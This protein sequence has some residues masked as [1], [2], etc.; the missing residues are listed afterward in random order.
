M[1]MSQYVDAW[2]G[3]MLAM[4]DGVKDTAQEVAGETSFCSLIYCTSFLS[5][6]FSLFLNL[7]SFHLLAVSRI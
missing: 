2:E 5:A 3:P 4:A 7:H 1:S 6:Y